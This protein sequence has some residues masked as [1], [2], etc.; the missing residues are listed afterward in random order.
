M[1]KYAGPITSGIIDSVVQEI[2]KKKNKDIIISE[3]IEPL[4]CELTARYYPH[5][6]T[7]IS[8]LVIIILLLISILVV[9]LSKNDKCHHQL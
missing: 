1:E 3:I 5:M 2:K 4:I 6:M 7:I 9:L 8:I